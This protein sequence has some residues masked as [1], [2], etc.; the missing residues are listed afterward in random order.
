MRKLLAAMAA[1]SALSASLPAL[2]QDFDYRAGQI[3]DRIDAGVHDGSLT[4]YEA[5]DLRSRLYNLRQ[6]SSRYA[7]DGMQAWE[8]RE[9]DRR[10]D[11]LSNDVY[12]QRHDNQY[13]YE[14]SYDRY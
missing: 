14:R 1:V 12:S 3:Q 2:A 10:F 7:D 4:G 6:L 11:A 8:R 9:L 5:R 13:R